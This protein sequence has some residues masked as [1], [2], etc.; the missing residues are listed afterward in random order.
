MTQVNLQLT[1]EDAHQL[2]SIITAIRT[3][4][5]H[6]HLELKI[7]DAQSMARWID[8]GSCGAR[9]QNRE[10]EA[11]ETRLSKAVSLSP[12]V[13]CLMRLAC[14]AVLASPSEVEKLVAKLSN[15][16]HRKAP[17]VLPVSRIE[18]IAQELGVTLAPPGPTVAGRLALENRAAATEITQ[19]ATEIT[20]EEI[21]RDLAHSEATGGQTPQETAR[22]ALRVPLRK[23]K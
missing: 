5:L 1:P 12:L 6:Q 4:L 9:P 21:S 18:R 7:L 11:M 19:S 10:L 17:K 20:Q 13:T 14:E 15:K 8:S 23:S 16:P 2:S 3:H 22:K